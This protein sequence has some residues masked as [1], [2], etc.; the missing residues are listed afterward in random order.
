VLS[1]KA[2]FS[3]GYYDTGLIAGGKSGYFTVCVDLEV[4]PVMFVK[5]KYQSVEW[6]SGSLQTMGTAT[7]IWREPVAYPV[8]SL[9][10]VTQQIGVE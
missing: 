4:I 8:R 7:G 2:T 1:L 10:H 9:I 3:R 6:S 5:Q